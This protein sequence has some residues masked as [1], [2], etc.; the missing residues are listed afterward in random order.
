ML[1]LPLETSGEIGIVAN[2]GSVILFSL[3]IKKS[4]MILAYKDRVTQSPCFHSC[5]Q[6]DY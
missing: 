1:F 2:F 3:P 4:S 5:K 6:A